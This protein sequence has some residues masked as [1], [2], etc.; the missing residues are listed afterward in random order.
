MKKPLVEGLRLVGGDPGRQGHVSTL[1]SPDSLSRM[2]DLQDAEYCVITSSLGAQL[3][4]GWGMM[5]KLRK[6]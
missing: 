1:S 2:P 4:K 3:L 6:P 5:N